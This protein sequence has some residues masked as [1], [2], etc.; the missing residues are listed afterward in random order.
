MSK[1]KMN[2]IS[3]LILTRPFEMHKTLPF[4]KEEEVA[5]LNKNSEDILFLDK[6]RS[7]PLKIVL[8]GEVKSGKS[9]LL[10]SIIGQEIAPVGV[11]ETT[12]VIME[13]LYG[14]DKVGNIQYTD[15]SEEKFELDELYTLL[16]E[17]KTDLSFT[18]KIERAKVT[19]PLSSL[20]N[21]HI[22]DTPGVETT[23]QENHDTTINYIQKSDVVVWV[24]STH[25]LGQSDIDQQILEVMNYGK[26][27]ILL[28]SRIDQI[29][30]DDIEEVMEF[31]EDNYGHYIEKAFPVSGKLAY[32]AKQSNDKEMLEASGLPKIMTYLEENI[33]RSSETIKEN[34]MLS[35]YLQILNKELYTS[36][37]IM[38]SII[39][40]EHAVVERK[41]DIDYFK[42]KIKGS[43]LKNS[44]L[45]VS[46]QLLREEEDYIHAEIVKSGKFLL[47]NET[48]DI[49]AKL[50]EFTSEQYVNSVVLSKY[51]DLNKN[52]IEDLRSALETIGA[53][54]I[55][56]ETE[57]NQNYEKQVNLVRNLD[58]QYEIESSS[59]DLMDGAKKGAVVGGAY[60]VAAATY[61]AVLGP[62]AAGIGI[63]A[64]VGAVLPPVLLIGAIT[65][66]AIKFVNKDKKTNA[67]KNA[68]MQRFNYVRETVGITLEEHTGILNNQIDSVMN[69]TY[70]RLAEIITQNMTIEELTKVK[71][72]LS[73]HISAIEKIGKSDV[74]LLENN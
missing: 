63:G 16:E 22:V 67:M 49:Q 43:L 18:S 73:C 40:L 68:A 55:E 38:E 69:E 5:I 58:S 44:K 41:H 24:L 39:F 47:K 65:G 4:V 28:I 19:F 45:W 25:H 15:G 62:Y 54:F 52:I 46:N 50:Q 64:A 23:T 37:A 34:T 26:P 32:D 8:M 66:A 14:E 57:Y 56:E 21:I 60:G 61:A 1:E 48:G 72:N 17:K 35:S 12:A 27:I 70:K 2:K 59:E 3:D 13:I 51:Q 11:T 20:Q 10:N 71:L 6:N 36:K 74:K 31:V 33:N 42:T 30:Q 9:T 53:K 29:D 7:T